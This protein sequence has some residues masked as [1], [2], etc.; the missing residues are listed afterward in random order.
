M[1]TTCKHRRT[2]QAGVAGLLLAVWTLL[3]APAWGQVAAPELLPGTPRFII[4][5]TTTEFYG[6]TFTPDNP[7]AQQWYRGGRVAV[8]RSKLRGVYT[9]TPPA[10]V[11]TLAGETGYGGLVWIGER[12]GLTVGTIS[13]RTDWSDGTPS[14]QRH[15]SA[16]ALSAR[17]W[18]W[19]AFGFGVQDTSLSN[20]A[21]FRERE[22]T[23]A[24]LSACWG[25]F[26]LGYAD[27]TDRFSDPNDPTFTGVR[28]GNRAGLGFHGG[29]SNRWHVEVSQITKKDFSTSFGPGLETGYTVGQQMLEFNFS[30]WLISGRRYTTHLASTN[31]TDGDGWT[32]SYGWAPPE[33]LSIV[34]TI[35]RGTWR[36]AGL[37]SVEEQHGSLSLG[38]EW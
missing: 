28:K 36:A 29:E 27:S 11:Y 21:Q 1:S 14:E 7:A 38:W 20:G 23:L 3:A 8:G 31:N 25:V 5:Q 37:D 26:C 9:P 10:G 34:A 17:P 35:E 2:A 30:G 18:P 33:G 12:S 6:T 32:L 16:A 13:L 4:T 19:L 22:T 15:A 24:G